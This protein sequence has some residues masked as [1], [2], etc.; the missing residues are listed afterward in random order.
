V[1]L[2]VHIVAISVYIYLETLVGSIL[3]FE[4]RRSVPIEY[5][6]MLPLLVHL[7]EVER[8]SKIQTTLSGPIREIVLKVGLRRPIVPATRIRGTTRTTL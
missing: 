4:E 5:R 3:R 7:C 2:D 6:D 8:R 1:G